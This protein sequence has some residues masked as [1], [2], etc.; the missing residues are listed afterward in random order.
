MTK[1][2]PTTLPPQGTQ[3]LSEAPFTPHCPTLGRA[4]LEARAP[5][6]ESSHSIQ[7]LRIFSSPA[8]LPCIC[9]LAIR[10]ASRPRQFAACKK[11]T[12]VAVLHSAAAFLYLLSSPTMSFISFKIDLSSNIHSSFTKHHQRV[13]SAIAHHENLLV[14]KA[15]RYPLVRSSDLPLW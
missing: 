2:S 4:L 3:P 11:C 12:R 13:P 14:A 10:S 5:K 7:L 9:T 8:P 1:F 15:L 6:L